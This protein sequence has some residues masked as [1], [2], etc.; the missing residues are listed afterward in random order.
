M[1]GFVGTMT[2]WLS[3][4][5]GHN[6]RVAAKGDLTEP[7]TVLVAPDDLHLTLERGGRIRLG[8]GSPVGGHRPSVSELFHSVAR[9]LGPRGIGLVLTGMG[10]DGADGLAAM[11]TA[12]A[13]TF[14]EAEASCAVYGMPRAA[15]ERGAVDHLL[16][17]W[18]LGPHFRALFQ[19]IKP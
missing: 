2:D 15:V 12:G 13:L 9:V 6:V 19:A 8:A 16:P 14:A 11:Q 17:L 18:R 5:T 10:D 4:T 1:E 7:G 3:S